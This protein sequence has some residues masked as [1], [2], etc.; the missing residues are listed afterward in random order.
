MDFIFL[1]RFIFQV[2]LECVLFSV[3]AFD[4]SLWRLIYKDY[5]WIK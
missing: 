4:A 1:A 5:Q 3:A 2:I